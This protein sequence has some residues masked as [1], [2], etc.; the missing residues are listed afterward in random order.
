MWK[1]LNP[2]TDFCLVG[3]TILRDIT[4]EMSLHGGD[5]CEIPHQM[6]KKVSKAI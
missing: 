3:L 1:L 4:R 2:I 6:E 5:V